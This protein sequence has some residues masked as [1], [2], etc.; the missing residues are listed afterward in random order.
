M[1]VVA[2]LPNLC[3]LH[4]EDCE[5][6]INHSVS[7][8]VSAFAKPDREPTAVSVVLTRETTEYNEGM[9]LSRVSC[10]RVII[11]HH[12]IRG[13]VE[14]ATRHIDARHAEMYMLQW[15]VN[16]SNSIPTCEPDKRLLPKQRTRYLTFSFNVSF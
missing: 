12:T 1:S 8:C 16:R 9:E 13:T 14:D 5:A 15:R 11:G 3:Y 4:L 10:W 6:I 7:L 2:K